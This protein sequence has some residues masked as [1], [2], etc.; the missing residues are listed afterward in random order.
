MGYAHISLLGP[1]QIGLRN[2]DVTH[3][4]HSQTAQFFGS[5]EHNRRE[6]GRHLRVEA[7]LDTSLNF[8][9]ALDQQVQQFLGIDHSLTEVGHQAYERC[10]PFVHNLK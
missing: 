6:T 4:Q 5:V 9:L 10:V 7:N 1:T 8:V 2:Q 3:A